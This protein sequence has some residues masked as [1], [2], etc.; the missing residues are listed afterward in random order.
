MNR[1][2][3]TVLRWFSALVVF[4]FLSPGTGR[5]Q[6]IENA[7]IR[8]WTQTFSGWNMEEDQTFWVD[9]NRPSEITREKILGLTVLIYSDE[10]TPEV[11]NISRQGGR[12]YWGPK[13]GT[14]AGRS[15]GWADLHFLDDGRWS[16]GLDRGP[17]ARTQDPCR[18]GTAVQS[19][20][21]ATSN[22][23]GSETFPANVPRMFK[24]TTKVRGSIKIDYACTTCSNTHPNKLWIKLGGWDMKNGRSKGYAK[25]NL[26]V[27]PKLVVGMSAAIHSDPDAAGKI[28]VDNLEHVSA[29]NGTG[30][31]MVNRWIRRSRGG[32]LWYGL[33]CLGGGID[34][35]DG[36]LS[37]TNVGFST[38]ALRLWQ[39][40]VGS[41]SKTSGLSNYSSQEQYENGTRYTQISY[42]NQAVNRG[43]AKIEYTGAKVPMAVPYV[44]RQRAYP[45]N[46]WNMSSALY[47]SMPFSN[48][49]LAANRIAGISSTILSDYAP[50][51]GFVATNFHRPPSGSGAGPH[52]AI[53]VKVGGF[54]LIDEA[55]GAGRVILN[56][57]VRM[58][59]TYYALPDGYTPYKYQSNVNRGHVLVDYLAGSCDQGGNGLFLRAIP[60]PTSE[61]CTGTGNLVLQASGSVNGIGGTKDDFVYAYKVTGGSYHKS[62]AKLASQD[63]FNPLALSGIMMRSSLNDDAKFVAILVKPGGGGYIR[64][65]SQN[66]ATA[67]Q[68]EFSSNANPWLR[69][70]WSVPYFDVYYSNSSSMPTT[71]QWSRIATLPMSTFPTS[72]NSYFVGAASTN[73]NS[74]RLQKS[75]FT[76]SGTF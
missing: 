2:Q 75:T 18:T 65:R 9:L 41:G 64:Y 52:D 70:D 6:L 5:A 51:Y 13:S 45:L 60:A 7:N 31:P 48:L 23:S 43:W 61:T 30:S 10:G 34:T 59:G 47:Y 20:F 15:G 53:D 66:G 26:A 67:G 72:A 50:T 29:L 21:A 54:T 46:A 63:N 27:D 38:Y 36:C 3:K 56:Q 74:S 58:S 71:Q 40:P 16:M 22:S 76:L 25:D 11:F 12:S 62:I 8:S 42:T 57:G 49:K 1:T 35:R 28:Q 24:S 33:G 55:E 73:A 68:Q 39:G 4:A 19:F 14:P 44:F 17:C 37:P 69:I 32:I